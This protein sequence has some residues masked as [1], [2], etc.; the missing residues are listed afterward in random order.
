M[1][2][3]RKTH[4]QHLERVNEALHYIHSQ[5]AEPLEI[6]SLARAAF[7]SVH[8]F[9]RIF[10]EIT[11]ESV[12][13]YIRRS[14]LEWAAN[15]L[16]F[17]P[18]SPIVEITHECGFKSSAS[19]NHAF[20][21][22]FG[23]TPGA[24][25]KGGYD[26]KTAQLKRDWAALADNPHSKY[27]QALPIDDV[28]VPDVKLHRLEPIRVAY[29]RHRGYDPAISD[30]WQ[31]LLDWAELQGIDPAGQQMLGLHHSNPDLVPFDQCRY[32][33]CLTVPDTVYR[34]RGIGVM[35]IPG[36]LYA[37]CRAGGIFGDLLY[38]MHDM[39]QRW[40]PTSDYRARN[41]PSHALY[42]DN[43]FINQTG[44]FDLEFRLPVMWK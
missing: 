26:L 3:S 36:G 10:R 16:V 1:S 30:C 18:D 34:S 33:A 19:F 14:R 5:L 28:Q 12:H 23:Y 21:A 4:N 42:F 35:N 44:R 2:R 9:Q 17:N 11:D 29:I 15:L 32:V 13:D 40:L 37:C 7:Y 38:L 22:H 39:T 31:R 6:N 8:H 20:K 43:H 41:I 25:R 24:W 27:Y